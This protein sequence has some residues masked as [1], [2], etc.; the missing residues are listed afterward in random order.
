MNIEV[1]PDKNVKIEMKRYLK[2]AIAE[3]ELGICCEATTPAAK[4]LF[5]INKESPTLSR[6]ESDIFVSVVCKLLYAGMRGRPDILTA[7]CFLTTRLCKPTEQDQSKLRC[8]LEYLNGTLDLILTIGTTDLSTM[9][10]FIDAAYGVHQDMRSQT[11]GVTSFGHGG[12]VCRA[13]KQKLN[14]KSST[15]A[16]LVGASDYLS[17]TIWIQNFM[18]AQGYPIK[19]SYFEQDNESAI[20]LETNGRFSA[21][22]K[23]RHIAIRHFW[24]TDRVKQDQIKIRHRDTASMLADFLTKPL[25][26]SLFRKFRDVILGYKPLSSLNE[27]VAPENLERVEENSGNPAGS[28]RSWSDVVREPAA[29]SE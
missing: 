29:R 21:G 6:A 8:L 2:E 13:S 11:G 14:T 1:L 19:N 27:P 23:S 16:E 5:D 25:Q 20:K 26:G 22:Q 12:I 24:I 4:N 10:T 28:T 3:S 15:E 7:L 9:Y 17:N 18:A